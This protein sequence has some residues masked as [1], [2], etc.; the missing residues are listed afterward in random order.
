MLARVWIFLRFSE[1]NREKN[2]ANQREVYE[3]TRKF[4]ETSGENIEPRGLRSNF[5]SREFNSRDFFRFLGH[6]SAPWEM[7]WMIF[8]GNCTTNLADLS[9]PCRSSKKPRE[10]KIL[11]PIFVGKHYKVLYR[12]NPTEE[13][14]IITR[15][16]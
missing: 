14:G 10:I 1:E 16:E 11:E 12:H 7:F 8:G 6:N 15:L 4:K 2:N 9:K 5:N 3:T 13:S